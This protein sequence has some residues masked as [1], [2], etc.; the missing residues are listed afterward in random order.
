MAQMLYIDRLG[1]T[2]CKVLLDAHGH[3]YLRLE[4]QK[5]EEGIYSTKEGEGVSENGL[6]S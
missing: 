1:T 2:T 4:Q 6:S 5:E 3:R